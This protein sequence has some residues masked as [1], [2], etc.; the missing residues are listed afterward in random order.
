MEGVESGFCRSSCSEGCRL[1]NT[2]VLSV[3]MPE[4]KEDKAFVDEINRKTRER[5]RHT[6]EEM[7]FAIRHPEYFIDYLELERINGE[8]QN[9]ENKIKKYFFGRINPK[10]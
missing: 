9:V 7:Q 8:S 6:I 3:I 2:E 4:K 5:E 10:T 1:G